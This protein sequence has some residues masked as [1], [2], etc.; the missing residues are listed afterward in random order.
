M[1]TV[2]ASNRC[3]V[4][5]RILGDGNC[6]FGA[7]AHQI[8]RSAVPSVDHTAQTMALREMV[9]E[10]IHSHRSDSRLVTL[11]LLRMR[12]EFAKWCTGVEY[13]DMSTFLHILSK[14]GVYGAS[15]SLL[16]LAIIFQCD[17]HV[18]R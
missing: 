10:Y 3:C 17:I 12:E 14:S 11:V 2:F 1:E 5:Q 9:F 16:T 6:L 4:V 7:V 8:F 13:E 18:F 15:E